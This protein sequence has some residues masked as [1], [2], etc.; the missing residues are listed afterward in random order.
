MRQPLRWR[1][2]P[3]TAVALAIAAPT[4]VRAELPA[5]ARA[6]AFAARG[7]LAGRPFTIRLA[8]A[9]KRGPVVLYFYP[10]AFTQGC[11]LEAHAFAE[12]SDD[13]RRAGATV[14]GMSSDDLATL[15]RFSTE[16][17]RDKFAVASATPA[18]IRAYDVDLAGE[19]G[20]TGL[21]KRT[22]YVIGRD[23]KIAFVHSDMDY[24][25]HV[26]L[27]LEAVK[28]LKQRKSA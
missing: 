15:Q 10:K 11:T 27:T 14:I 17:C 1:L 9:L 16:A 13:F 20:S 2:G 23:G 3:A 25:D 7:A 26:R 22:S 18:V 28:K 5:G 19:G 24:R 6:P 8:D 12:A 21:T 4:T